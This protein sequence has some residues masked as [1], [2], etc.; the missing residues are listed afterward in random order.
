YAARL[1]YNGN[2]KSILFW[3]TAPDIQYTNI[4]IG[5]MIANNRAIV[6]NGGQRINLTS[7]ANTSPYVLVVGVNDDGVNFTNSSPI[8]GFNFKNDRGNLVT[9]SQTGNIG[10]RTQNPKTGLSIGDLGQ[11]MLNLDWTYEADWGGNANRWAG[12]IG[13]N[14]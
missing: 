6:I 5:G 3:N 10:I 12:F 11:S 2:K 7:G 8:R 4:E 9:I 14:A 13:F 1:F